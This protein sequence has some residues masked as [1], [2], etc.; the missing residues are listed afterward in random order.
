MAKMP[1]CQ[2]KQPIIKYVPPLVLMRE[3]ELNQQTVEHLAM[4]IEPRDFETFVHSQLESLLR[5]SAYVNLVLAVYATP[6][7][8]F[9]D[10]RSPRSQEIAEV[11]GYNGPFKTMSQS[12]SEGE[13]PRQP[14]FKFYLW[15]SAVSIDSHAR[16]PCGSDFGITQRRTN[17]LLWAWSATETSAPSYA[18]S[19]I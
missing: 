3:A 11:S 5:H 16:W 19:I 6:P 15:R 1:S 17:F 2:Q 8:M 4:A 12:P 9:P 14:F 13:M 10:Y 7:G 18:L